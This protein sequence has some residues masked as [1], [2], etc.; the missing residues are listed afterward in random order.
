MIATALDDFRYSVAA[1]GHSC[2]PTKAVAT[3]ARD[4]T[5]S[6]R[7]KHACGARASRSSQ[8]RDGGAWA[9]RRWRLLCV[10]AAFCQPCWSFNAGDPLETAS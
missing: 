5:I 9:E 8:S 2:F 1:L 10:G 4:Q 7:P 6:A 3:N